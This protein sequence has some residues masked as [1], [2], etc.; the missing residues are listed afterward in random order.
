MNMSKASVKGAGL[1]V[2]TAF[3][4]TTGFLVV[5][6]LIEQRSAS[7]SELQSMEKITESKQLNLT[8]LQAGAV[9]F[10]QA[11]ND[12]D[13]FARLVSKEKDI[14]SA[15]RAIS[16]AIISGITIISFNFNPEEP[17]AAHT[18]PVV[19]LEGYKPPA[20]F[21]KSSGSASSAASP[22]SENGLNRVPMMISV[23]ASSYSKL[24]EY[25]DSLSKQERLVSVISVS[26]NSLAEG[27]VKAD[28]YAYAFVDKNS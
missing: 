28:I 9:D 6:P 4:L 23:S 17:V 21:G 16:E 1:L 5:N 19:S 12:G 18:L 10:E 25:I 22:K 15:S 3:I 14:E 26:A 24:S 11:R 20:S 8:R 7:L 27:Q 13:L 2:S